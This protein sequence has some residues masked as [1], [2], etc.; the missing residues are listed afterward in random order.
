[1]ADEDNPMLSALNAH[2]ELLNSIDRSRWFARPFYEYLSGGLVWNDET[3]V[4]FDATNVLRPLF[5]HRSILILGEDDD[6]WSEYWHIAKELIP[7]WIGFRSSRCKS[8][9]K[10]R[11]IIRAGRLRM[12]RECRQLE[13][14]IKTDGA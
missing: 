11:K 12:H 9:A 4:S 13:K 3:D 7:N 6:T 2:A 14:D 10:L 5:R 8:T 1:M